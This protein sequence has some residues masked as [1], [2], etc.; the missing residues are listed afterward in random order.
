MKINESVKNTI[1]HNMNQ[2]TEKVFENKEEARIKESFDLSIIHQN[3]AQTY[4]TT[5]AQ[6]ILKNVNYDKEVQ[7]FSKENLEGFKQPLTQAQAHLSSQTV[8][9][10]L[11]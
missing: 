7:T 4:D 1:Y 3:R 10:L 8:N 6:T 11:Q 5:Q 2:K 9:Q